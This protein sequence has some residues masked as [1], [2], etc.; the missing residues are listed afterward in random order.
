MATRIASQYAA[1]DEN[2]VMDGKRIAGSKNAAAAIAPELGA[3][4]L[5]SGHVLPPPRRAFGTLTNSM[6]SKAA[7][8]GNFEK[9]AEPVRQRTAP[10]AKVPGRASVVVVS[11]TTRCALDT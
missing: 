2:R 3:M 7:A 4:K 6:A 10:A 1:N 8:G 9:K 5:R 11:T